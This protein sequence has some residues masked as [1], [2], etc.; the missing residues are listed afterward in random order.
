MLLFPREIKV[1]KFIS[2]GNKNALILTK[3]VASYTALKIF[4]S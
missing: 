3:L 4:V 1:A 2:S